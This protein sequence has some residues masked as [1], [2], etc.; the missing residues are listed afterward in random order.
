[1]INVN[2]IK[3][4]RP[5]IPDDD[6]WASAQCSVLTFLPLLLPSKYNASY[7]CKMHDLEKVSFILLAT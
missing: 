6:I 1:M 5:F 2:L 4:P 7:S 3:L